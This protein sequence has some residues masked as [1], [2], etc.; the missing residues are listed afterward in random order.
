MRL[1]AALIVRN[2]SRFIDACLLSLVG[3]VDEIVVVDT[4]STDDTVERVGRYPAILSHFRWC[5]D[6]AAARNAAID[7]AT[8]DWILYIDADERLRPLDTAWHARLDWTGLAAAR[9]RLHP[10]VGWTAYSELRLFR[11]DPRIRFEGV[12]HERVHGTVNAVC[13]ED[14][15][16]IGDAAV[17]LDHVGYEDDPAAKAPRNLP[18]LRR[19]LADNPD[20]IYCWWHLG[21]TLKTIGDEAGAVEAWRNGIAAIARLPEAAVGDSESTPYVALVQHLHERGEPVGELL[22]EARRRFPRHRALEWMEAKIALER[23]DIESALPV[24]EALAGVDADT[25]HDPDVAYDKALFTHIA[26]ESLGLSMFRLGRF[27]AAAEHYRRA[28]RTSPDCRELLVKA[29]LAS[30]RAGG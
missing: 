6:F 16:A 22:R 10:R 8:G 14:G 20:R 5:D 3:Q 17:A 23:G 2:E 25:F 28:A 7:R 19:Y 15:L 29:A 4:G 11:N 18:L 1:S 9:L 24:F 30:A 13:R 27:A 21:D 12:V 26:E